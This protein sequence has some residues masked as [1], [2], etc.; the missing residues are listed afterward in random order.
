MLISKYVEKRD[1]MPLDGRWFGWIKEELETVTEVID[2]DIA[3]SF[4]G[5]FHGILR[6]LEVDPKLWDY[7]TYSR[8]REYHL[9]V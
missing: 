9:I 4:R 6:H 2:A 8:E 7:I 5:D 1:N 3:L